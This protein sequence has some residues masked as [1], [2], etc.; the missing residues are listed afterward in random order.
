MQN[1]HI[2]NNETDYSDVLEASPTLG[3]SSIF[4]YFLLLC[5][6]TS[7]FHADVNIGLFLHYLNYFV[8]LKCSTHV[9]F[10]AF[11]AILKSQAISGMMEETDNSKEFHLN[12]SLKLLAIKDFRNEDKLDQENTIEEV[13]QT[14][15]E[16]QYYAR[17][18]FI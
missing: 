1:C 6:L 3:T 8:F 15:E 7:H 13:D 10:F 16:R 17:Q 4:L 5:H 18:S 12:E 14:E 2:P 11:L 9:N